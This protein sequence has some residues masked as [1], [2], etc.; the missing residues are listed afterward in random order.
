MN[1]DPAPAIYL[2]AR[3]PSH[4][5]R[6]TWW[7]GPSGKPEA[8]VAGA[9][10]KLRELDAEMPMS[11]VRTMEQWLD[12]SAAQPRFNAVLLMIF[13]RLRC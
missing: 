7:C 9:R 13:S 6:W 8:A 5:R 10:Q 2:A 12:L 11:G 4:G 1:Q 3:C